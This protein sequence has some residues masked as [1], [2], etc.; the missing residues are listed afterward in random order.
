MTRADLLAS[1]YA[2]TQCELGC[3]N[4]QPDCHETCGEFNI[5]VIDYKAGYEACESEIAKKNRNME[6]KVKIGEQITISGRQ[7]VAEKAAERCS[8][9]GC[10]FRTYGKFCGQSDE[11]IYTC[12]SNDIVFQTVKQ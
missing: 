12:I 5:C 7:Y 11:I 9:S 10:A 3:Q 6:K 1:E 4:R 2:F 8:C